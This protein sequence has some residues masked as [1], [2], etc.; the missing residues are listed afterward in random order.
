MTL[1]HVQEA[2]PSYEIESEVGAG[3][4]TTVYRGRRRSDGQAVSIKVVSSEFA[5][6]PIFVRRFVEAAGRAVR[7]DHP[8]IARVYE[9]D[10]H[11]DTVYVVRQFVEAETLAEWLERTG[12]LSPVKA[13]PIVRQLASALDYAHSRRVMHGDINDRCIYIKD[14]GQVILTDFGL[15]QAAMSNRDRINSTLGNIRMV[16]GVENPAYLAPERVQGQGPSRAAD[17]YALGVVAYQLLS[18]TTPFT[19][20]Q[21]TVLESQ[22]Y[23]TPQPLPAIAR[24]VSAA[25]SSTII[26]ALSKKPELRYSTAT[27]FSRAFAAAAEGIAPDSKMTSSAQLRRANLPRIPSTVAVVLALALGVLLA[28]GLWNLGG[29]GEQLAD[30][31]S[32]LVPPPA[33]PGPVPS[34]VVDITPA[35]T[36]AATEPDN[37]PTPEQAIPTSAPTATAIPETPTTAPTVSSAVIAE[38]SPFANLVLARG[39]SEDHQPLQ[40]GTSFQANGRPVYLFFDYRNMEA[41]TPWSHV[42]FHGNEELGR[43]DGDWSESWGNAGTAWVYYAPIGEYQ[44]GSYTVRL[45][46]EGREVASAGFDMR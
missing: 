17:I 29:W 33:S 44:P 20:D 14:N 18:N 45:Y 3:N 35:G 21:E 7:L 4:L 10:Q 28:V 9:A 16:L 2:L 40:A 36:A 39:I 13:A 37:P 8:N 23:E 26:R 15:A 30:R 31:L 1:A 42:W 24:G 19:G 25:V 41:G 34:V 11:D 27:E 32:E 12:P 22:V 38:G 46:V 43:T 5:A 6:D